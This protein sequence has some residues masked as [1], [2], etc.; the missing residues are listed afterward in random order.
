MWVGESSS[1]IPIA[2]ATN[3][4]SKDFNHCDPRKCSGKKLARLG[5]MKELRIGGSSSSAKFRGIVLS[6]VSSS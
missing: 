3:K 1:D 6:F 5:L 2:K 4:D